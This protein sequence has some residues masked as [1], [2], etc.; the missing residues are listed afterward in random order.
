MSGL[1]SIDLQYKPLEISNDSINNPT[2]FTPVEEVDIAIANKLVEHLNLIKEFND[3][4]EAIDYLSGNAAKLAGNPI[5]FTNNQKLIDD[6]KI[7]GGSGASVD[8]ELF[9]KA[10]DIV[11]N[12]FKNMA[13]TSLTG[14]NND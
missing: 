11:I 8:F 13:L 6:I 7:L 9:K 12:G 10:V 4:I 14:V 5:Y 2:F 1:N 3:R